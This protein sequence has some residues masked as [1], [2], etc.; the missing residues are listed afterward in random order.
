VGF[1][2][3]AETPLGLFKL[4]TLQVTAAFGTPC[5]DVGTGTSLNSR[6]KTSYGKGCH[7]KKFDHTGRFG[8]DWN[9]RDG[10]PA[11]PSAPPSMEAPGMLLPQY[12]D[13]VAVTVRATPTTCLGVV[14]SLTADLSS[15]PAGHNAVFTPAAGNEVGTLTWQPTAA[16]HGDFPVTIRAVGKNPSAASTRTVIIR[17]ATNVTAVEGTEEPEGAPRLWQSRPNPSN[18]VT[19]IPY[20]VP[21]ETHVRLAVY[22]MSGRTVAL[23]V[24]R[25]ESAGRHE[26]RWSGQDGRG[27][28]VASG[29][30]LYRLWTVLGTATGRLV[31]AR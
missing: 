3:G 22:D 28:P 18:P 13:P 6:H 17:L 16:D 9:D 21:A 4:G 12:L 31:L 5:L 11:S 14:S 10:L 19:T 1:L 23:L 30:Y 27:R 24:D 26:V 25:V 15:L 8:S 2:N 20:W 29:V 7:G